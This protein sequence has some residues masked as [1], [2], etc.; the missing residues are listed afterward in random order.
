MANHDTKIIGFFAYAS[1]NEVLCTDVDACIIT[2][3]QK[4]MKEYLKELDPNN[5][6]KHT[7]RKTRF[8][9]IM[10]GL[11]LGAKY[12]FDEDS[13]FEF[14]PL[15]REEGLNVEKADFKTQ[16]KQGLRFFT[17]QIGSL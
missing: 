13:Y 16:A 17:V 7:V 4:S 8:G 11:K 15:A 6:S 14:Y 5:I 2:G 10:N 1:Q 3:S 9:E 12:A